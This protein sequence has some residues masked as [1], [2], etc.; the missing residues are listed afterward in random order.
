M[1]NIKKIVILHFLPLE[2][3]PPVMNMIDY[4]SVNT[5]VK[6]TVL[7]TLPE[8]RFRL[9]LYGNTNSN[10]NIIRTSAINKGKVLRLFH[11]VQYY[12]TSFYSLI[13]NKPDTIFYID[14]LSSFSGLFYKKWISR[15]VRL[16]VHYNE[17]VTP[18]EYK[19]GMKL[20]NRFHK[21]ELSL[22]RDFSW[23]SQTNAVRL[24][25]FR[26]D[27]GMND[28][29][30][31]NI[32]HELPN[33]PPP[34]WITEKKVK[35][36]G[37]HKLVYVG[38]LGMDTMYVSELIDWING[39]KGMFTLDIYAYNVDE[40]TKAYL[41]DLKEN[42]LVRFHGGCDYSN[43]PQVLPSYDIG[44][45]MYKPFSLNTIHAVSNKIM[46][47][48]AF[49]LDV[50]FS[51]EMTHSLDYVREDCYPKVLAVDFMDLNHF[52]TEKAMNKANLKFVPS[53][54]HYNNVYHQFR[55]HLF[56]DT[57]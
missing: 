55:N 26:K 18:D 22:Y 42:S 13:I 49:G 57:N 10:V 31:D 41:S 8:D 44:I 39:Q 1:A 6:I 21:M 28:D 56:T 52:D 25:K 37:P 20:V 48:L 32:F 11:Y 46:E 14:T 38:S 36:D 35:T 15:K 34:H 29:A 7:T 2:Q 47:Y 19:H 16:M 53:P 50:W 27:I 17:Y 12:L 24:G 45:V 23:I 3:Y 4:L 51:K 33:Y 9:K 5:S 30:L 40:K 43:L 54:Y